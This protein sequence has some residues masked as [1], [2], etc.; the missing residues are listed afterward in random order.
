MLLHY[1]AKLKIKNFCRHSADMDESHENAKKNCI[2]ADFN[3]R[4]RATV[5]AECIYVLTE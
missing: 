2:Y 1:I 5:Y 3:S 4:M